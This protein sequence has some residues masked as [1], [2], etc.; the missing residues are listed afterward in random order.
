MTMGGGDADAMRAHL[1][2][3]G[4][5]SR[6]TLT[7]ADT[8]TEGSISGPDPDSEVLKYRMQLT[9]AE[10]HIVN[11]Q[12]EVVAIYERVTKAEKRAD[13]VAKAS[14]PIDRAQEDATE[15]TLKSQVEGLQAMVSARDVKIEQIAEKYEQLN[16]K[17]YNALKNNKKMRV[18][19]DKGFEGATFL[20]ALNENLELD[21]EDSQSDLSG[22]KHKNKR[23]RKDHVRMLAELDARLP[24]DTRLEA[25]NTKLKE[26]LDGL[27]VNIARYVTELDLAKGGVRLFNCDHDHFRDIPDGRNSTGEVSA[28]AVNEELFTE[29]TLLAHHRAHEKHQQGRGIVS[30]RMKKAF[31]DVDEKR[32]VQIKY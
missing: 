22:V 23:L 12:K 26:H 3:V 6:P 30:L 29:R 11:L 10:T 16:T 18:D 1:E 32:G 5:A 9:W 25:E 19:L 14:N 15:S 7:D 28:A 2:S 31:V 20:R 27:R 8:V 13:S 17:H 21:M 24:P 4:T